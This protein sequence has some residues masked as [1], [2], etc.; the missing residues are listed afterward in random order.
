MS[1]PSLG[2][3]SSCGKCTNMTCRAHRPGVGENEMLGVVHTLLYRVLQFTVSEAAFL[4]WS[5]HTPISWC[6]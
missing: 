5:I 6:R 2:P 3:G 1:E 4:W